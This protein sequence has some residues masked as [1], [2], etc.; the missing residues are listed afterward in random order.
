MLHR[1][2]L[3]HMALG[4][5]DI[6]RHFLMSESFLDHFLDYYSSPNLDYI[7]SSCDFPLPLGCRGCNSLNR[8]GAC[9]TAPT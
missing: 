8:E 1:D 7:F 6:T 2:G 4:M 9:F 5:V 3:V